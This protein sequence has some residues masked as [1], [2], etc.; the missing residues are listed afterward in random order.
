MLNIFIYG[1]QEFKKDIQKI[2]KDS[3]K[4]QSLDDIK[5]S[6]ISDINT[7]KEHII[8]NADDVYLID[9]EKIIKK[10]RFKLLK[11]KDGIEEEF[12]AKFKLDDLAIETLEELPDYIIKKYE[13]LNANKD[14]DISTQ[15]LNLDEDLSGLLENE[16]KKEDDNSNKEDIEELTNTNDLA[17]HKIEPKILHTEDFSEN[18]G[19][20]NVSF[21]YD[22]D[23]IINNNQA[24]DEDLLNDILNSNMVDDEEYEFVGETFEDINF[25]DEVFPNKKIETPS[26]SEIE[27]KEAAKELK[28]EQEK[29]EEDKFDKD[30]IDSSEDFLA[31]MKD[32]KFENLD[33]TENI[34]ENGNLNDSVNLENFNSEDD[35][36]ATNLDDLK[37]YLEESLKEDFSE[38][39]NE[40]FATSN[41][42]PNPQID[43]VEQ[44]LEEDTKLNEFD[45]SNSLD[46]VATTNEQENDIKQDIKIENSN[47]NDNKQGDIMS[48]EFLELDS[49]NEKDLLDAL[50]DISAPLDNQTSKDMFEIKEE[51]SVELNS[52]N[53]QDIANLITKLLNNK[54]LEI[55]IK[56]KD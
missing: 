39:F 31:A 6:E 22:D 5:I 37:D 8:A 26:A 24:K 29:Q 20:N 50:S 16:H 12:L 9:D 48:D 51:S 28:K 4:I 18:F 47:Q 27:Q 30:F 38:A 52:S 14:D 17:E 2:L 36:E 19:L 7:L 34:L 42:L 3:K 33:E 21:D 46:E 49:L 56:I 43:E 10:S 25:L 45:F 15:D 44:T 23:T 41:D 40:D 1:N 11:N 54:T 13:K 53:V 35:F 55:T 32:I